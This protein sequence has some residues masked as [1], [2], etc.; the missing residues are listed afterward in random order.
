MEKDLGEEAKEP[1]TATEGE[2]PGDGDAAGSA[3]EEPQAQRI[4]GLRI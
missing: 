4:L 2:A 3:A 1:K